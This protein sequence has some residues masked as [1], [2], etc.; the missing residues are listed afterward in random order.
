MDKIFSDIEEKLVELNCFSYCFK[1]E[2][3]F[4]I[5]K[6]TLTEIREKFERL[7]DE[8]NTQREEIDNYDLI[9]LKLENEVE[10][11]NNKLSSLEKDT[12]SYK[13]KIND[14][15]IRQTIISKLLSAKSSNDGLNM[16]RGILNNDFLDFAN[17]E[18]SIAN[19]AEMLLKLQ[20]IEKDLQ[21][22]S[23]NPKLHTKKF[24]AVGGGFSAGKSE[25]I[26]SFIN[27]DIKLPIGVIPTTAI[28]TYVMYEEE[29][30]YVGCTNT[31]GSVNLKEIDCDIQSKF[32]HEFIKSFGFN[33]KEIMPYMVLGTKT[34][35]GY[36]CFVDTPGYNPASTVD[37]YTNEDVQTAS[38]FLNDSDTLLWLI[39]ADANGTIPASDLEFLSN[40]DIENKKIYVVFNKADLRPL[41]SIED[42]L[43][44]IEESLDDYGISIEGISAYSSVLKEEYSFLKMSLFDFLEEENHLVEKQDRMIETLFIV[45][46]TYKM[47]L[48][49]AIKEK[50]EVKKQLQAISLDVLEDGIEVTENPLFERVEYLKKIFDTQEEKKLLKELDKIFLDFKKSIES[51]FNR[52]SNIG[53]S[54]LK[55]ENINLDYK[56]KGAET[57]NFQIVGNDVSKPIEN[58]GMDSDVELSEDEDVD[59]DVDAESELYDI[60]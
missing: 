6:G 47:G 9:K 10:K 43:E 40:I 56:F 52:K 59:E 33:L 18:N 24:I 49:K 14:M 38:S 1:R 58:V 12:Y 34:D 25:F 36:L 15:I 32:T 57:E 45:H 23:A 17:R 26:S 27:S 5:I 16:Y 4:E 39:G 21:L 46:Y 11:L 8:N 37:G 35:Y 13:V 42:V 53:F 2:K 7:Y 44:E 29:N 20:D 48:L 30:S 60:K 55:L 22:I 19:E 31:G 51:V 41:G 3:Y 54:N 28:P 50:K